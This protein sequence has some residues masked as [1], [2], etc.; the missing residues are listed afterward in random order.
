MTS[1]FSSASSQKLGCYT[2]STTTMKLPPFRNSHLESREY[3]SQ[4]PPS[5]NKMPNTPPTLREITTS[6]KTLEQPHI[7][8]T[9]W[10]TVKPLRNISLHDCSPSSMSS[11]AKPITKG[12]P[13]VELH[14]SLACTS[15][16]WLLKFWRSVTKVFTNPTLQMILQ[17]LIHQMV[18]WSSTLILIEFSKCYHNKIWFNTKQKKSI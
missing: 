3:P 12:Q 15:Y 7:Q 5:L 4:A 16:L 2:W 1:Q 17:S 11:V 10:Y 6:S 13:K 9:L 8:R 18:V 14:C